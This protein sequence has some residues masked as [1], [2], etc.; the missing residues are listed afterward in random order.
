MLDF[1]EYNF[2]WHLYTSHLGNRSINIIYKLTHIF[3]AKTNLIFQK[4][5]SIDHNH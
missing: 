1:I 2:Y 3:V 4:R 5:A